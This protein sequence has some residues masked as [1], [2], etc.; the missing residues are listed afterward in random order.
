MSS[1]LSKDDLEVL[2]AD[3]RY[4]LISKVVNASVVKGERKWTLSDMLDKVF[5]D[6]YLGIPIFL[7]VI[8]FMFQFTFVISVILIYDAGKTLYAVFQSGIQILIEN[9]S[10]K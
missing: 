4:E 8:W 9:I 6:K 1:K 5:L 7:L 2:L 10:K 3:K